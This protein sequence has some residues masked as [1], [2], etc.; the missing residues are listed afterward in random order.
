MRR[1][2]RPGAESRRAETAEI[3]RALRP[4]A[5]SST[6]NRPAVVDGGD[7]LQVGHKVFVGRSTVHEPGGNR[8]TAELLAPLGYSVEAVAVHGCLHLKS[9][10]TQVADD[11]LLVN[12][13]WVDRAALPGLNFIEVDP[14]EPHAANALRIGD[15]MLYQ[16]MYPRTL[17]RLTDAGLR[18]VPVDM[19]ELAKAEGGLTCCSLIYSA[20]K[21]RPKMISLFPAPSACPLPRGARG[22][23]TKSFSV[24]RK[25]PRPPAIARD[26]AKPIKLLP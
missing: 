20:C 25:P 1:D 3:A 9:A 26:W 12:P 4:I 19:S 2:A 7:V 8:P 21:D 17:K 22:S 14:A 13:A 5:S 24:D 23:T 6:S 15:A 18:V 16:P 10:V 11:T